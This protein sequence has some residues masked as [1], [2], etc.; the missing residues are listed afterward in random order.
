MSDESRIHLLD[1][2]LSDRQKKRLG[3]LNVSVAE[4]RQALLDE[5]EENEKMVKWY[6]LQ[7]PELVA[8][9]VSDA[10]A[11]NGL[12]MLPPGWAAP[13]QS[14]DQPTGT[15]AKEARCLRCAAI[16]PESDAVPITFQDDH[17]DNQSAV[18]CASCGEHPISS[19]LS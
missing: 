17:G 1:N 5:R 4:L 14:D 19:G 8:K 15:P 6:C 9:M 3:G 18:V 11:A 7:I 2:G 12:T 10:L 16:V 13:T